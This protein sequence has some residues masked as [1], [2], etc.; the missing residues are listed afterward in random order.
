MA[1]SPPAARCLHGMQPGCSQIQFAVSLLHH[2]HGSQMVSFSIALR[3][4][5]GCGGGM[6][7]GAFP[8]WC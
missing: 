8:P 3:V 6:E 2:L 1:L 4:I 5:G 7:T